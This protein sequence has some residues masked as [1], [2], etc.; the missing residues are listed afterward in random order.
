MRTPRLIATTLFLL[1]TLQ[2]AAAS[3][4]QDASPKPIVHRAAAFDVSPPLRELIKLPS[5]PIYS[6][7]QADK[8]RTFPLRGAGRINVDPVEQ[9]S[10]GAPVSATIGLNLLGVDD[11]DNLAPPDENLAIG[12]TQVVQWVNTSYEVFD[13]NTGVLIAGPFEG[14][15][16][17]S[18]FSGQQCADNNSGD[19]IAQWDKVHHRWLLAQNEFNTFPRYACIAISQTPDATGSYY[20][21]QYALGNGNNYFPDYPKWGIWSNGYYQSNN[22]YDRAAQ[23]FVGAAPCVYNSAKLLV[24]DQW[25]SRFASSYPLTTPVCCLATSTRLPHRRRTRMSSSSAVSAEAGAMTRCIST[26]FILILPTRTNPPL[27]AI[28]C[29]NQLPLPAIR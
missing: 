26:P 1:I 17:W 20:R 22:N 5:Q 6:F 2:L 28:T 4:Q 25:L 12:D 3:G 18:G 19:I 24:G 10:A 8:A 29:L 23:N 9:R 27:P 11:R 7:H 16:L 14:N 13:K 21:Y 15:T